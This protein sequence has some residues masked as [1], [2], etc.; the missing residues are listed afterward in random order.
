MAKLIK[1]S[2]IEKA[3]EVSEKETKVQ[4]GTD[5]EPIEPVDPNLQIR[6]Q[7]NKEYGELMDV[8]WVNEDLQFLTGL[9]Y[10]A[11]HEWYERMLETWKTQVLPTLTNKDADEETPVAQK[12]LLVKI[13]RK[14]R[15]EQ[16]RHKVF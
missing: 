13:W 6:I 7:K 12:A 5:L 8:A 10:D 4:E 15:N 14:Q 3:R 11:S 2:Q 1:N 16:R 9:G